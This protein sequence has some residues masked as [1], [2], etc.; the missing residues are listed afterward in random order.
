MK[1]L[2]QVQTEIRAQW[3]AM[4]QSGMIPVIEYQ[5]SEDDYITVDIEL[6]DDNTGLLFSFDKDPLYNAYFSG[7]VVKVLNNYQITID[8]YRDRLD[9]YLQT[10]D[11]NMVEGY[12]LPNNL[13]YCEG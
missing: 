8:E 1:T 2:Q 12:L 6:S 4:I 7:E 5:V 13:Y 11:S 9:E 10:I 3:D